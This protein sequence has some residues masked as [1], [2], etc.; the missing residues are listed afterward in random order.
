MKAHQYEF[1]VRNHKT[2]VNDY[3]EMQRRINIFVE[4]WDKILW[5]KQYEENNNKKPSADEVVAELELSHTVATV[6]LQYYDKMDKLK[7]KD[8]NEL[9]LDFNVYDD[10]VIWWFIIISSLKAYPSKSMWLIFQKCAEVCRL[11]N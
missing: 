6:Y 7:E 10:A 11:V 8:L 3:I 5:I 4:K 2:T 1:K 9:L